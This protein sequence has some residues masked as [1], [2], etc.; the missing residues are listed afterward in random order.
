MYKN[1]SIRS[2][3]FI[4][5][6]FWYDIFCQ[7]LIFVSYNVICRRVTI[8]GGWFNIKMLSYQY[9]KSNCGDKTILRPSYLHNGISNPGK[10]ISLFWIVAQDIWFRFLWH[11]ATK[12]MW[13]LANPDPVSRKL[14]LGFD[15]F[16]L[17]LASRPAMPNYRQITRA[18]KSHRFE[19]IW[20]YHKETKLICV[21]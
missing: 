12:Q 13:W 21:S 10:T 18:V 5:I 4:L 14:K 19:L 1:I 9:R 6:F 17:S 7:K 2:I 3:H 16:Q 15:W 20:I 11:S 8:S